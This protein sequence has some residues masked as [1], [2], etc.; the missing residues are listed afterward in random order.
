[1]W[2]I[3]AL[4]GGWGHLTRACA[5]ARVHPARI[6]TNS[7]HA[8]AVRS[9][10][11]IVEVS[12]RED[13]ICQVQ[14]SAPACLIVDTFPRGLGGELVEVLESIRA[15]KVLVHRDLNPRYVAA[16]G[17]RGFVAANYD[18]VLVP[19]E[20]EGTAFGDLPVAKTTA[21]W[22]VRSAGELP[23]GGERH[24]YICAAG[25]TEESLWYAAVAAG[26]RARGVV[27]RDGPHWPAMELFASGVAVVG[28]GGYNTVH[29]CLALRVPLVARVWPRKYDRQQLRLERAARSGEVRFVQSADEAVISALEFWNRPNV[30]RAAAGYPNGVHEAARAVEDCLA[31]RVSI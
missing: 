16:A 10:F 26:L 2:L 20:G 5:L 31:A 22:L 15:L 24:V 12:G 28:G 23:C 6:L 25:K 19:G 27:V 1:M 7:P 13:V 29:E 18:L 8:D 11:D 3:Y 30:S 17:L 14:A 9:A 21:P 4:G